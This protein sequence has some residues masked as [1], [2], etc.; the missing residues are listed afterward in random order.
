MPEPGADASSVLHAVQQVIAQRCRDL[1]D[2]SYVAQLLRGGPARIAA[3][4]SEETAELVAAVT[5]A[6]A[7]TSA[8]PAEEADPRRQIIHEAADLV[9]HTLVLLGWAHVSLE[10]VEAELARRM[11]TS[12]L[13]EKA[14]RTGG[15]IH[16]P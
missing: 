16:G 5:E 12:G 3:K 2:N 14:A 6:E 9:F 13:T 15:R 8:T 4:M 10:D 7:P 1:P 11:G